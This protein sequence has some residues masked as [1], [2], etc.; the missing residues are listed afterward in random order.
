MCIRD[1]LGLDEAGFKARFD[2]TPLSRT[3]RRGLLRNVS[4]A[5]GNVGGSEA[6]PALSRAV[7]DPEP[8]IADHAAWAVR[9]IEGRLE[10]RS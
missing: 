1:R 5:L 8:L 9:R 3:R 6:L 2:G 10:S 7:Q 4:V